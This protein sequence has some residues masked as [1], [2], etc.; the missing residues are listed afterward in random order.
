M[1]GIFG[2]SSAAVVGGYLIQEIFQPVW[3]VFQPAEILLQFAYLSVL[4]LFPDNVSLGIVFFDCVFDLF[5]A[6]A[7]FVR[8]I[9]GDGFHKS[10]GFD[11]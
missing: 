5:I 10:W 9:E 11:G 2:H 3:L 1:G 6:G 4:L 8:T 7:G